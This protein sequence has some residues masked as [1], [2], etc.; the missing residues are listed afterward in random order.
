MSNVGDRSVQSFFFMNEVFLSEK[1]KLE[2][3]RAFVKSKIPDGVDAT[4][5]DFKEF[6]GTYSDLQRVTC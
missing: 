6:H 1:S 5:G 2:E 3:Q 4:I